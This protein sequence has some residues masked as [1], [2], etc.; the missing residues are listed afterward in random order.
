MV[1]T[2]DS[3]NYNIKQKKS[4]GD[5]MITTVKF[6][7]TKPNAI[8]P[9]KRLEDAGYDVYPC[10][11]E[12]YIIIKPH[13]TVVIP[14]GVASACDT[15]Y[16]FVLHERS[17]TGTKGMAQRCG[18]IDSGY[19]GEWGVPIT[20]TNDIPIV[21]CK[22]ESIT[23]FNDFASILLFSYGEANYILYPYEKAICQALVLP[24]PEVEIEEYTYEE[25]KAIPSERGTGRLGSSG[26]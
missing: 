14:T 1:A 11:D 20:N 25:L 22:K 9:T 5:K 17:S 12:D 13:T 19:R 15:D 16:C 26:K 24:V 21:I 7:K 8:I 10:F 2:N 18:I 23:D 6:A 3:I 4:K